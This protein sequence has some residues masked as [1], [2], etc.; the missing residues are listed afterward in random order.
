MEG[1]LRCIVFIGLASFAFLSVSQTPVAELISQEIELCESGTINIQVRFTGE[2]PYNARLRFSNRDNGASSI[3]W[4]KG[5]PADN[6]FDADLVDGVYT[7]ENFLIDPA[8]RPRRLRVELIETFDNQI[9]KVWNSAQNR[10][11]WPINGGYSG[12]DI[13]G[14]MLITS[15]EMPTPNA[16]I[17]IEQCGFTATLNATPGSQSTIW[18]WQP[19][20]GGTL[21]DH[22]KPDATF[23]ASQSG[24]FQLE[25]KQQNGVCI[26]SDY[27]TVKL[28]GAPTGIISTISEVCGA[29]QAIIN[30]ALSGQQPFDFSYTDGV[31]NYNLSGQSGISY[32]LPR[33][34]TGETSFTLVS[35]KDANNCFAAAEA[36]AG[37][38][39]VMDITPEA[40]AGHDVEVCGDQVI[41]S[42]QTSIGTGQWSGIN[43]IFTNGSAPNSSFQINSFAE[44]AEVV[45][46]WTVTNGEC[47]AFDEVTVGFYEAPTAET[48]N[49]GDDQ[50]LYHKFDTDL[51]AVNPP[52]GAGTWTLISGNGDIANPAM[53][54]SLVSGLTFGS[55]TFRWTVTNGVCPSVFSDVTILVKGLRH[56]T[57]F[58]PNNDGKND[59]FVIEGAPYI[60]SNELIVFNQVGEVVYRKRDYQNT[61]DGRKENGDELP[62]GYYYYIFTGKGIEPIKDFLVLRRSLR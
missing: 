29:G 19:V 25:L 39:T 49:A 55:S 44:Y 37:T 42:A 51:E 20:V 36:M 10:E 48:A 30:I 52:F 61:W 5:G 27:V 50:E 32:S 26:I 6:I 24:E 57:G 40:F 54:N 62:E 53:N 38:A 11:E 33:Q 58:S 45:L 18:E 60:D 13:S 43:G 14:E 3:Q 23:T 59:R 2:Q 15:Y 16:G 47:S 7:I 4:L 35:I 56:P 46:K 8:S 12:E 28:N 9:P 17:D 1:W 31:Q 34:V 22:T 21:D 41:L